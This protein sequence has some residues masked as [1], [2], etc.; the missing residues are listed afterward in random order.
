MRF[1]SFS[2]SS[3][4]ELSVLLVGDLAG[5]ALQHHVNDGL[6]LEGH[7]VASAADELDHGFVGGEARLAGQRRA[8]AVVV[9][10]DDPPNV[11][12][13]EGHQNAMLPRLR[14]AELHGLGDLAVVDPAAMR[15]E[16]VVTID[17]RYLTDTDE[18]PA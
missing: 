1:D 6:V 14:C 9:P 5:L 8:H 16:A 13:A 7:W 2:K 15:G 10:K 18:S 17:G 11:A 4:A 12:I 3:I